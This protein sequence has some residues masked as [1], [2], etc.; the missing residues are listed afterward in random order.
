MFLPV[1]K[2]R[3]YGVE[4]EGHWK[5]ICDVRVFCDLDCDDVCDIFCHS[6]MLEILYRHLEDLLHTNRFTAS[7]VLL[8]DLR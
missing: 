7:H 1:Y 3:L 5:V 2:P 8:P 6:M 4:L